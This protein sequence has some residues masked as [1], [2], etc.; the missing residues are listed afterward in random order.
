MRVLFVTNTFPPGYTGGAEVAN[1]HTCQGLLRQGVDCSVLSI[2]TRLPGAVNKWYE[3]DNILVHHVNFDTFWRHAWRDVFDWRVYRVVQA[4]LRRLK[5]DLVHIYNVSGASLAPYVACRVMGVPVVNTLHDLWLLC[6]NNMLYRN[7]GSFCDP[8]QNSGGCRDCYRRY[9]FWGDIP[10]RRAVFARLTSNVNAFISPSQ[11]LIDRHVEAGYVPD[12]FRL[13]RLGF[14]EHIP[15]EP[16]HPGV[17]WVVATAPQHRTVVFAGGGV[18]IK[19]ARVLLQAIPIILRNVE[20]LRVVVAGAGDDQLLAQ[21]DQYVP[22][23]RVLGRVP[24]KE[25]RHLFA[26]ADLTIIP[27]VSHE[28]SPVVIYENFHVGTPVVGSAFGGIPELIR[29]GET[30]Y[31]FPV[32]DATALAE[33]VTHHFARPAHERRRMRQSCVREVRT[34]LTLEKHIEGTLQVYQE[35]L[36]N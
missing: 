13:V 17:R 7:D 15:E 32:G 14:K 18:E 24:F 4:E 9:D 11:A 22:D 19:G 16:R 29:D 20:R 30:G 10:R 21:F 34:R 33:R 28:N 23:V 6:P 36:G 31:L 26:V 27:S 1:Y 35:V 5:P 2:N 3:I 8:R 12:R 25:M